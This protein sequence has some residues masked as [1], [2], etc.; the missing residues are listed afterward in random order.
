MAVYGNRID[1]CGH[2]IRTVSE[3]NRLLE[4]VDFVIYEGAV[5]EALKKAWNVVIEGIKHVIKTIGKFIT[6]VINK[7]KSIFIKE[8]KEEKN[9]EDV[10]IKTDPNKET[11]QEAF[12]NEKEKFLNM[13]LVDISDVAKINFK[14][15]DINSIST[16]FSAFY[17]SLV[18]L[19]FI[20]E[21]NND[22]NIIFG[23][24]NETI[25]LKDVSQNDMFTYEDLLELDN[26]KITV[27]DYID[28]KYYIS[29]HKED[30]LKKLNMYKEK[31]PKMENTYKNSLN[32]WKKLEKLIEDYN[33]SIDPY[34]DFDFDVNISSGLYDTLNKLAEIGYNDD[35]DLHN[36]GLTFTDLLKYT[37]DMI[38]VSNNSIMVLSRY[39]PLYMK[40]RRKYMYLDYY[41][42]SR[43][44][45][46]L[47]KY[48][49]SKF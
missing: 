17:W 16:N 36:E 18:G 9:N 33:K 47:K 1:M 6:E 3:Q 10:E 37:K 12:E 34:I 4:S 45:T 27:K 29:S 20:T 38:K 28:K 8:K 49:V 7:I 46:I 39:I 30:I 15:D 14:V 11:N 44:I 2:L 25:Y 19:S 21:K 41:I 42:R 23:E 31:L 40:I 32:L 48:N 24:N 35:I 5:G 26:S 22:K 43:Q 13:K